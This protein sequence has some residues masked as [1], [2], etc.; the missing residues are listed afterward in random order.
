VQQTNQETTA[1]FFLGTMDQRLWLQGLTP[2]NL[3]R[4]TFI[5]DD[6]QTT[7]DE[8]FT[9]QG[10]GPLTVSYRI[11]V[12]VSPVATK[13]IAKFDWASTHSRNVEFDAAQSR[14]D[15][16]TSIREYD[17]DFGD[18]T[19]GQ[20]TVPT[21]AHSF[22][23]AGKLYTVSLTVVDAQ[24]SPSDSVSEEVFSPRTFAVKMM[25]FIPS[26][27]IH[28]DVLGVN[29][30][31]STG[32]ICFDGVIPRELIGAGDDRGFDAAAS[33]DGAYRSLQLTTLI[34]DDDQGPLEIRELPGTGRYDLGRS[35]SYVGRGVSH[36]QPVGALNHGIVGIIDPSDDDGILNDC[37]LHQADGKGV[38]DIAAPAVASAGQTA[39]V[40]LAA[41]VRNGL[42]TVSPKIDYTISMVFDVN[43]SDPIVT[44]SGTR[45]NFPAYEI[46]VNDQPVYQ[47]APGGL[48]PD[49][50]P[51]VSF[52]A[53]DLRGLFPIL[54]NFTFP[55][56]RCV[57]Y[58]T[59]PATCT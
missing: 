49:Q 57:L 43:G 1:P 24:G 41:H 31:P 26:N 38:G 55:T 9:F 12:R 14:A 33:S 3:S 8:Q 47:F 53:W 7:T 21:V 58:A 51:V 18:G 50:L 36:G 22:P 5:L 32:T 52:G 39:T 19:T 56:F 37:Y 16:S 40:S 28:S 6:Q 45:D 48:A 29:L 2:E 20:T 10:T 4:T 11:S 44:I 54:G 35:D 25:T 34:E 46:Y 13:P 15:P 27:Y 42:I 30:H 17:W 23:D 59:S